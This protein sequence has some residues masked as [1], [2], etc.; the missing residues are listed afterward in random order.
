[1]R[2]HGV[3]GEADDDGGDEVALGAAIAAA[4]QPDAQQTGAPPDNTHGGMLQVVVH[5]GAAP[6]VLG[7]GVDASPGGDDERVE[8][9]LAATGATEPILADEQQDRQQNAVR[10]KGAAHD[11]MRQA[12]AEVVIATEAHGGNAA[13]E[14]LHPACDGHRLAEDT[15]ENDEDAADAAVNA[16]GQMELEVE[17]DDHL[18][19]QHE[20]QGV[21]KGRVD[22]FRELAAF[23]G[24]AEE[25]GHHGDHGTDNL[26]RDMPSRAH[27]LQHERI[28]C[29]HVRPDRTGRWLIGEN[30]QHNTYP[31]DH[32][33]REDNPERQ[34]HQDHMHP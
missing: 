16:L 24:V 11:E 33:Q 2:R 4:T 28:G 12:L 10:D 9:L 17:A 25:I 23:V 1:M 26:K 30:Q 7:E 18:R 27:N 34:T 13:E 3:A 31:E 21:C 29:Q 14:H 15:V 32:T 20:H 5:P 22:V 6:A 19:H 8:E